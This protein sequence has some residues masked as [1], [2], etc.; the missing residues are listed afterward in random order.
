MKKLFLYSTQRDFVHY[1]TVRDM[2]LRYGLLCLCGEITQPSAERTD[3]CSSSAAPLRETKQSP[4][5]AG[6]ASSFLFVK[7]KY[8]RLICYRHIIH[9]IP[10]VEDSPEIQ[11]KTATV[12][13]T[14]PAAE[15]PSPA[16]EEITPAA[17]NPSPA[18]EEIIPAAENPYPAHEEIIPAAENPLLPVEETVTVTK[19][20]PACFLSVFQ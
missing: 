19:L 10:Q 18:H 2:V 17:E 3:L 20:K 1:D 11:E 16:H 15:N 6:I 9:L 4:I 5:S 12:F 7:T 13:P 8:F 14:F